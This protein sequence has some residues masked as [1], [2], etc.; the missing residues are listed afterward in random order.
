MSTDRPMFPPRTDEQCQIIPFRRLT[1]R[2]QAEIDASVRAMV[3]SLPELGAAELT[4]TAKNSRLRNARKDAWHEAQTR[5]EYF[6]RR[7]EFDDV[8]G[9]M[10]RMGLPE[11]NLHPAPNR[12]ETLRLWRAALVAQ[13]LLPAP[14]A[15]AVAWKKTRLASDEIE[16]A[17]MTRE[18]AR[19]LI[20][21]DTD[22][23]AAHPTKKSK[24]MTTEAKERRR[25]FK[26]AMRQR[27]KEIA[28]SR[29]IPD[30]EIHPALS[31]R[32]HHIAK[33]VTTYNVSL[34]WLLEG[35]GPIFRS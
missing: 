16:R 18:R 19:N 24:P 13:F 28:A 20:D 35:A 1:T 12:G 25:N 9:H 22:F 3:A 15:G 34:G 14:N 29:G 23:L 7:L 21:R 4:E 31:L 5:V 26:E 10:Q 33:F 30:D 11:G 32:H 8:V 17:G 27:I 6:H 2:Q